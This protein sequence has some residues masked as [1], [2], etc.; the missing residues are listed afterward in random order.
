MGKKTTN[1]LP[2]RIKAADTWKLLKRKPRIAS[3][4]KI[5]TPEG[6]FDSQAE[7]SRWNELKLLR[8]AGVITNL[9][10]QVS[11]PF[12]IND[13]KICT[14]RADFVYFDR[15]LNQEIVEDV[16]GHVTEVFK[17]KRKL[18]AACYGITILETAVR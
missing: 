11:Y 8:D 10:R 14:Y 16:K 2:T 7:L 15:Q 12:V 9:R 17:L 18:M 5:I 6:T 13:L 1:N 4:R 3:A